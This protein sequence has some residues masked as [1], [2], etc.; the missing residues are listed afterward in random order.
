[1]SVFKKL[2]ESF[3]KKEGQESIPGTGEPD[4]DIYKNCQHRKY[5]P[6]NVKLL[7]ISSEKKSERIASLS[8]RE[9]ETFLFL[10]EGFTLKECAKHM[11]IK[12]STVNT[13]M[14]GCR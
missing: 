6:K 5:V 7:D 1:M 8:E 4:P 12:Y 2:V 11:G 10:L 9:R 3:L 13:Y 14:T